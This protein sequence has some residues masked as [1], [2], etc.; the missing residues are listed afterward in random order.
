VSILQSIALLLYY[1]KEQCADN[2]F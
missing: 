2:A 1:E